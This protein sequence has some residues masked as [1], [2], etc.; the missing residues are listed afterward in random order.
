MVLIRNRLKKSVSPPRYEEMMR[1]NQS[2]FNL[3]LQTLE[4]A[5]PSPSSELERINILNSEQGR[6]LIR[7]E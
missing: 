1:R 7:I 3:R 2:I 5:E 6:A 4:N